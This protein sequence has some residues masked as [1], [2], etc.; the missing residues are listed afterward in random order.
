LRKEMEHL[1]GTQP[2]MERKP[3]EPQGPFKVT[4]K[5]KNWKKFKIDIP[6]IQKVFTNLNQS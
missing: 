2:K 4:K 3:K 1:L 5:R 6:S